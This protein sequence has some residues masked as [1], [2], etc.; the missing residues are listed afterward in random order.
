MKPA[1]HSKPP[2]PLLWGSSFLPVNGHSHSKMPTVQQG[3]VSA[4]QASPL[5]SWPSCPAVSSPDHPKHGWEAMRGRTQHSPAPEVSNQQSSSAYQSKPTLKRDASAQFSIFS[6]CELKERH[7]ALEVQ[8]LVKNQEDR[9]RQGKLVT[10]VLPSTLP[11]P[12][13]HFSSSLSFSF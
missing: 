7:T 3:L 4:R 12:P 1:S 2:F 9:A 10:C 5:S 8:A 11:F 6:W 13:P